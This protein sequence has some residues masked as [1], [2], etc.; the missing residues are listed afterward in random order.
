MDDDPPHRPGTRVGIGAVVRPGVA[1]AISRIAVASVAAVA[2]SRI[3]VASVAAITVIAWVAPGR[4]RYSC[5]RECANRKTS[6]S[7][8]PTSPLSLR[9]SRRD[10]G[11]H[12]QS[13]GEHQCNN[14]SFHDV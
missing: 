12:C 1:I 9:L 2:I 5:T 13:S 10:D 7:P 6:Q 4:T 14:W 11:G 3:A 8:T